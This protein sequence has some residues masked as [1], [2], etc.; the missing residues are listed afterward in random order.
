MSTLLA[1]PTTGI[2][3]EPL[4]SRID[5]FITDIFVYVYMLVKI[6]PVG[7]ALFKIVSWSPRVHNF[8]LV[9]VLWKNNCTFIE[10]T[11]YKTYKGCI[12]GCM[13]L[14]SWTWCYSC[15]ILGKPCSCIIW[16]TMCL[17]TIEVVQWISHVFFMSS[18]Y[19]GRCDTVQCWDNPRLATTITLQSLTVAENAT[20]QTV[21][22]PT[23]RLTSCRH[24]S[25][26][27]CVFQSSMF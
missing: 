22:A 1:T 9:V 24:D 5:D 8:V 16:L 15:E 7:V 10:P 12:L 4:D 11:K 20:W 13:Q 3:T 18:Y 26:S 23:M 19:P 25:S 17:L 21:L 2:Q 14:N 6:L 27:L